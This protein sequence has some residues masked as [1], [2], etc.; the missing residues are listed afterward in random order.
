[1]TRPHHY[2]FAWLLGL[3]T[4]C[5]GGTETGNPGTASITLAAITSDP[6]VATTSEGGPGHVIR[7]L[8][9]SVES[10]GLVG[11]APHAT[12]SVSGNGL[13]H[14]VPASAAK[15]A[16]PS[17]DYCGVQFNIAGVGGVS[18][19]VVRGVRSDGV[20]FTIEDPAALTV[21]LTSAA[22]FTLHAGEPLLMAFDLAVWFGGT[23]LHDATPTNGQ[24]TLDAASSAAAL[25]QFESQGAAELY[26][27][28]N[29][30]G[31]VD[32]ADG[33][34]LAAGHSLHAP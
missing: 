24:I 33:P 23:F 2:S 29:G 18:S 5:A 9:L 1:M 22:P 30:D 27:D 28:P 17:G 16:V 14:L 32:H 13:A 7:T 20:P 11:C 25:A 4:A 8:E 26:R 34:P 10:L 12:R 19:V 31:H 3:C 21:T 15:I 6:S